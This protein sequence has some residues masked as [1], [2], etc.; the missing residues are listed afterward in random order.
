MPLGG[1]IVIVGGGIAGLSLAR[2]LNARNIPNI[3]LE[4]N[5]CGN[6]IDYGLNL[7]RW[8][9]Q[10]LCERLGWDYSSFRTALAGDFPV[11]ERGRIGSPMIDAKSGDP[12]VLEPSSFNPTAPEDGYFRGR[13][14]H[15]RALLSDGVDIR[16]GCCAHKIFPTTSG[17]IVECIGG[18]DNQ[19]LGSFEGTLVV[20]ADAMNSTSE[21]MYSFILLCWLKSYFSTQ[22]VAAA[23]ACPVHACHRTSGSEVYEPSAIRLGSWSVYEW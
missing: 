8:A 22:A 13:F 11:G 23:K 4:R 21:R 15:L 19:A 17:A 18:Q 2:V 16:Y 12:V 14:Q 7:R 9:C 6:R 3:V 5:K 10:P 20:G 1:R